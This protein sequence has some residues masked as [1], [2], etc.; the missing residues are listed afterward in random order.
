VG[1]QISIDE[2]EVAE[3]VVGV[4]VDVL[5]HVLVQHRD[6]LRIGRVPAS[7][8]NLTVL[9]AGELVVL[10][11]EIGLEDL[12]RSQEPENRRISPGKTP[13]REGRC[14]SGQQPPAGESSCFG[15]G[16]LDQEGTPAGQLLR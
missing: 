6:S 7:A 10:L 9:D 2:G 5:V 13:A 15:G 14:R 12:E 16:S 4:V 1:F 11:P 3:L 8:G